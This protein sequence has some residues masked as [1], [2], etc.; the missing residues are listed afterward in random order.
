MPIYA[1]RKK[2]NGTLKNTDMVDPKN[3][4]NRH[5]PLFV[6]SISPFNVKRDSLLSLTTILYLNGLK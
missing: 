2:V 5:S 6:Q 4:P 3:G 1:R